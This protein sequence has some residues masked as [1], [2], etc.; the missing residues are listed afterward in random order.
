MA[1]LALN[2]SSLSKQKR[3]LKI[4]DQVLPSL[5]LKR[6]QLSAEKGKCRQAMVEIQK[7]LE[8][9]ELQ[10]A[11][12]LP[13]LSNERVALTDIVKVT[14]VDLVEE[15]IM[16]TRLPKIDKVKTEVRDYALLEKPFWVDRVVEILKT[17]LELQ[18]A[19]QVGRRRLDLLN[20]AERVATQRFNLFEKVL[21][22]QTE[23]NIK[24]IKIYLSDAER[25]AVVNSKIAKKKKQK[26]AV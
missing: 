10:I 17:A 4:Y 5:D 24:K 16:G 21:T 20:M 14:A 22:P 25:A 8:I 13:M 2:K 9:I 12:E 6:R 18:I 3:Q 15:N 19:V 1:R 7:K 26:R 23:A 11:K